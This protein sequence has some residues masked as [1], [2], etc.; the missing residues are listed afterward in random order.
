MMDY[1]FEY[2]VIFVT[3]IISI[4]TPNWC[5]IIVEQLIHY[6]YFKK[7]F[8]RNNPGHLII[9]ISDHNCMHYYHIHFTQQ[10]RHC[11]KLFPLP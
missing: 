4:F 5:S 10:Y 2:L 9:I 3:G 1:Y 7:V 11:D 8:V 6:I